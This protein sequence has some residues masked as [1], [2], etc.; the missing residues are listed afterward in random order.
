MA[1]EA[2]EGV[3]TPVEEVDAAEDV[4]VDKVEATKTS[5]ME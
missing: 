3:A 5:L 2:R 1:D 4:V